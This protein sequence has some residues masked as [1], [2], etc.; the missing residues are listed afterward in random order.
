ML[1]PKFKADSLVLKRLKNIL[2]PRGLNI[3]RM[4]PSLPSLGQQ[5]QCMYTYMLLYNVTSAL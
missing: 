1:V 5:H 4:D 3:L 2:G